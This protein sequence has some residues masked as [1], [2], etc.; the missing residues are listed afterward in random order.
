LENFLGSKH[1]H[2][3]FPVFEASLQP[4][5]L[6]KLRFDPAD[7]NSIQQKRTL[8]IYSMAVSIR[9]G[10]ERRQLWASNDASEIAGKLKTCNMSKRKRQGM[11]SYL[12]KH[13]DPQM[14][15]EH[16]LPNDIANVGT[17]VFEVSLSFG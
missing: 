9:Q 2:L 5:T 10:G 1:H 8:K 7:E 12:V 4:G 6:L 14:L 16:R 15:F 17:I 3:V 13:P 11:I